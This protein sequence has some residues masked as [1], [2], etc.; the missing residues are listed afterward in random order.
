MVHGGIDGHS[1]MITYLRAASC[2]TSK[3]AAC[4][5]LKG[6]TRYGIPSRVRA[7]CGGEFVDF[8]HFMT[9][10]NGAERGSFITGKSVHNQ[11]IE[12]LWR[13]VYMKV[14]VTY[15]IRFHY[16]EDKLI[17]DVNNPVHRFALHYTILPR[18]DAALQNWS[19]IHNNH[20]LRTEKNKTLQI[21]WLESLAYKAHRNSTVVKNTQDDQMS[22]VPEI[23]ERLNIS[24]DEKCYLQPRDECPLSETDRK[25][26]NV[27]AM[28]DSESFG[29]D[30][31]G[32]VMDIISTHMI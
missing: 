18:I 22:R 15:Y 9:A 32:E 26:L 13:D 25:T 23:C 12:R 31:S 11:R 1:R 24:N 6:V 10:I 3:G 7:D 14:L 19:L 2:N 8:G 20:R 29:L 5:F 4:F 30:I 17:L 28:K 21:I 16:M 27:N